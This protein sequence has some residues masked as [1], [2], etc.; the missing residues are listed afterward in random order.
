M[1]ETCVISKITIGSFFDG[2]DHMMIFSVNL[3]YTRPLYASTKDN[4]FGRTYRLKIN[5]TE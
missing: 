5:I 2:G 1:Q 3:V 4:I